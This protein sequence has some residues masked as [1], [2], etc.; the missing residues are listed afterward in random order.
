MHQDD[1]LCVMAPGLGIQTLFLK[2]IRGFS[3]KSENGLVFCLNATDEVQWITEGL[4]SEGISPDNF[5]KVICICHFDTRML[6]LC[7]DCS[8]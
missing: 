7:P 4:R 1:G 2:F 8:E 6:K 5:P 3:D